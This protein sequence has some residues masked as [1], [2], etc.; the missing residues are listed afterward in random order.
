MKELLK[1]LSFKDL[2]FIN[3]SDIIGSGIFVL[4]IYVLIYGGKDTMYAMLLVT[5]SS[6]ISGFTYSEIVSIYKNN[7]S[8][9]NLFNDIFGNKLSNTFSIIQSMHQIT[10]IATVILAA[11]YYIFGDTNYYYNMIFSIL[12]L[13]IIC[14][15]NYF[16]IQLSSFILN[17]IGV[18]TLV[19]LIFIIIYGFANINKQNIISKN[20]Y[21]NKNTSILNILICSTILMFVFEGYDSAT[22]MYEEIRPDTINKIPSVISSSIIVTAI[23]YLLL[24]YLMLYVFNDKNIKKIYNPISK[25][26]KIFLGKNAYNISYALG[27]IILFGTCFGESLSTSR[28]MYGL[29]ENNVLPNFLTKLSNYQTPY[30]IIL[31]QFVITLIL[32]LFNNVIFSLDISNI[33]LFIML[34]LVNI[35]IVIYRYKNREKKDDES[36]KMPLYYKGIPI[37]PIINTIITFNIFLPHVFV[38]LL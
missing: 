36:Y 7:S 33:F 37:L 14:L 12:L 15:L 22:K 8:E 1:S 19:L 13:I 17:F 27:A 28:Y 34:L 10:T 20:D 32:I 5:I 30:Y 23:I 6:I 16:G 2:F 38:W 21:I 26:Y 24:A 4:F 11:S 35:C 25:L 3:L 29:S 31:L 9:Y 18:I